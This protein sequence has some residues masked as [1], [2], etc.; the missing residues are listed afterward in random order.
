MKTD[1]SSGFRWLL[2]CLFDNSSTLDLVCAK[3]FKYCCA[4]GMKNSVN[5]GGMKLYSLY[6]WNGLL[7][8]VR[9]YARTKSYV[10]IVDLKWE[11]LSTKIFPNQADSTQIS[12]SSIFYLSFSRIQ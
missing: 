3:T 1:I 6:R 11:T 7:K 4:L 12:S 10:I 2:F 5:L 8:M 9:T